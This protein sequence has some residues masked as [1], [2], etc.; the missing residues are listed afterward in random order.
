[1]K[2]YER[3]RAYIE[4]NHLKQSHIAETAGFSVSTFNAMLTGRRKMYADDLEIICRA[5]KVSSEL[6][7]DQPKKQ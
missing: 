1:M 4:E 5:L 3:V 7:I 2:V 6:F